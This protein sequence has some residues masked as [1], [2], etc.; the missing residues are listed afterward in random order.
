MFM[1]IAKTLLVGGIRS[2]LFCAEWAL[3]IS[4]IY[5]VCFL[6]HTHVLPVHSVH[7]ARHQPAEMQGREKA[8][9]DET[10]TSFALRLEKWP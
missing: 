8:A 2:D 1:V 10:N 6:G 7:L 5:G 4:R 9:L 3:R